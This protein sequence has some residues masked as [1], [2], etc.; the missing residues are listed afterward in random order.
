MHN[1]RTAVTLRERYRDADEV[2]RIVG[3]K[4]RT[5]K[6]MDV[7]V[8]KNPT[9]AL[10][11]KNDAVPRIARTFVS[12]STW[13]S[14]HPSVSAT[15]NGL[16]QRAAIPSETATRKRVMDGFLSFVISESESLANQ[17]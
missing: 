2:F 14:S 17:H 7:L 11:P 4:R 15:R 1:E 3:P 5:A 8:M 12:V 9:T 13:E 10:Y 6:L 16:S